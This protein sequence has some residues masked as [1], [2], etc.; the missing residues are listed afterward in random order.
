MHI[1]LLG[2]G[3]REHAFAYKLGE[4]KHCTQLFIAP[5][6]PGTAELGTNVSI[7]VTDFP[8]IKSF[9]LQKN[10][11]L[12]VVGPE[13]PLVEGIY[14]FFANDEAL[15]QIPVFGPSKTGAQLEGS[16]AFSKAF[17]MRHS[18]PTAAYAEFTAENIHDG[19]T[20][21][22]KHTT[23][24][25]LKADGLAAGKGVLIC[26]TV[27]EAQAEFKEML[28]GKFGD[29]ST[30]V[31]VEEFMDGIEFSVFVLTD[32]IDYK[33]LPTAK[34][35]K[36][37]GEGDTGLNTGGMG[38]VSPPPFVTEEMLQI[39]EE[40]IIKP[41]IDGLNKD[42]IIYKGIVYVGLMYLKTGE[43]K[44]V[45][46]NC[47]MGDPETEAVFPRIK[48]DLVEMILST[49]QGKLASVQLEIDERAATTIILASGGYPEHFEKD[50]LISG[51]EN[52]KDAVV[53]Q[54]GTKLDTD[55]KLRTNGGRVLAV[56]A[57]HTDWKEALKLANS[58]AAI[59]Q[60]ENKYYRRDIGF[61]L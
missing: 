9:V 43:L 23:P 55:G 44:V 35:Y 51:I 39:T 20:Y 36:R 41:T 52:V 49:M 3:G 10:I 21:I 31:V 18:I 58:N 53:L 8:A 59:V 50:K 12:I 14:D 46:Y 60:F 56:T 27:E 29:A 17:M 13:V 6:N 37:I 33:I 38:A 32:G 1:L 11:E 45:E 61:D 24:I 19:L 16:K 42:N 5:G 34:D 4:S 40:T 47:R 7:G 28:G 57:L 15:K 25:V 2:S 30:K 22:A 26:T 48:S 54:C